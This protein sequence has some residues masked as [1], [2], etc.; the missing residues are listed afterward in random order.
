MF[1]NQRL[2]NMNDHF[3]ICE[4][5]N[6]ADPDDFDSKSFPGMLKWMSELNDGSFVLVA[7]DSDRVVGSISCKSE[8]FKSLNYGV[9][10]QLLVDPDYRKSFIYINLIKNLFAVAKQ[11]ELHFI[12]TMVKKKKVS[13]A[14]QA[15]GFKKCA[16]VNIRFT[17]P[18]VFSSAI[19]GFRSLFC[20]TQQPTLLTSN[21]SEPIKALAELSGRKAKYFY[22]RFFAEPSR[23]Y[24]LYNFRGVGH[25]AFRV[26]KVHGLRI[27]IV[28][29]WFGLDAS[30]NELRG[31][32]NAIA[33]KNSCIGIAF[34]EKFGNIN[35]LS[36][37]GFDY[38]I[39][40]KKIGDVTDE[41]ISELTS[42]ITLYQNDFV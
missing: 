19:Y 40:V 33:L 32:I 21:D 22:N 17:L 25:L 26:L 10:G 23:K 12:F 16:T 30:K 34:P 4:L 3:A 41:K 2:G 15:L 13:A 28:V 5:Q 7:E 37:K 31:F 27:L 14:N 6:R 35:F 1:G 42:F 8:S 9:S 29:D 38:D 24:L 18:S 36:F 39:L 11:K 20:S